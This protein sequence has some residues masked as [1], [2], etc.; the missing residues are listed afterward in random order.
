[1]AAEPDKLNGGA[2]CAARK[3]AIAPDHCEGVLTVAPD[4]AG[5]ATVAMRSSAKTLALLPAVP[6]G[7][8]WNC[9]A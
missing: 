4:A 8:C 7:L 2:G 3:V 9:L 5:P 1:M 6:H